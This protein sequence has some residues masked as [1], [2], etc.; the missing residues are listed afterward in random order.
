MNVK[1]AYSVVFSK[2]GQ[3]MVIGS[4]DSLVQIFDLNGTL[5]HN[6]PEIKSG[7]FVGSIAIS[8]DEQKIVFGTSNG[9]IYVW[10]R[11]TDTYVYTLTGQGIIASLIFTPDGQKFI[12]TSNTNERIIFWD[13]NTG[14]QLFNLGQGHINGITALALSPDGLKLASFG[15]S[16]DTDLR[17]WDINKKSVLRT[18]RKQ[19]VSSIAFSP[20][21]QSIVCGYNFKESP[22][23]FDVNTGQ[24]INSLRKRFKTS[25]LAYSPDNLHV[26]AG[27][28]DANDIY[29]FNVNT[30]E[31]I[32]TLSGHKEPVTLIMFDIT[33]E[34]IM[35][36]S[37]RSKTVIIYEKITRTVVEP[38]ATPYNPTDV[39]FYVGEHIDDNTPGAYDSEDFVPQEDLIPILKSRTEFGGKNKVEK[40]KVEKIKIEEIN[41]IK[42]LKKLK[43]AKDNI[44]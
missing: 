6:L 2:D 35:T 10:D 9:S 27:D 44:F 17:I 22:Y 38:T 11:N 43:K 18:I 39:G 26:A 37:S 14:R 19:G 36:F 13:V 23:T 42:K 5:I 30:G 34:K 1:N 29:I 41:K 24:N 12:S 20:D 7:Y 16:R 3:Y 31:N 8:P 21:N 25:C 33:G 28:L 15:G 4:I 32:I 40:I